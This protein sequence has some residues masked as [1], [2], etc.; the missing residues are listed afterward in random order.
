TFGEPRATAGLRLYAAAAVAA[1]YPRGAVVRALTADG[2]GLLGGRDRLG[3]IAVG[4]PAD[5]AV[6][7]GDPLDPSAA[8]R[9]TISQGKVTYDAATVEISPAAAVVK[10]TLPDKLPASYVIKTTRLLTSSGLFVPGEL[11]I[12]DGKLNGK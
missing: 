6:F 8:V 12:V 1:G 10:R 11:H 2:A 7:A 3:R 9:M 5:L 4:R